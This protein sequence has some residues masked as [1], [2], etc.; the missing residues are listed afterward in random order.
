LLKFKKKKIKFHLQV[1]QF[2]RFTRDD[3]LGK[4]IYNFLHHGDHARFSQGLLPMSVGC[5]QAETPSRSRTFGC[6]LL[7]KPPD[8]HDETMEEKQQRVSKY[9]TMQISSMLIP[10]PGSERASS[11]TANAEVNYPFSFFNNI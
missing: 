1:S 6:R 11:P 3:I 9:E 7:V 5:W 10:F 8:E 2:T 4:S